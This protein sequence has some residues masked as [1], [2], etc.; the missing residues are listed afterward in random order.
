MKSRENVILVQQT[1]SNA[2]CSSAMKNYLIIGASSG[3]GYE[4][5][6]QLLDQGHQVYSASRTA[7]NLSGIKHLKF[8]VV[9]DE[10][11]ASFL[12]ESLD[13]LAYCPGS[14]NLKP[15]RSLKED[16]YISDFNINVLGAI[17]TIKSTLKNLKKSDQG[18]IVLFSTVAV[19]TGLA[20]HASVAA[21][22]GAVEGITRSLAAE[23]APKIRVN[24]VAPSLTDTPLASNLLST[25]DK[26]K[27]SEDR[28]PLRAIGEAKDIAQAASFLLSSESKW[29]TGQVLGVDG[30]LGTLR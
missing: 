10:F 28:H 30:G 21:A 15:F 11:D 22:K 24:A 14:I 12:P 26:R 17:R 8:D 16:D 13:G 7:P 3:I 20:Y 18:S 6:K 5:A 23:L 19:Q 9:S 29:V 27:S 4:L 25:E 1:Y 2:T